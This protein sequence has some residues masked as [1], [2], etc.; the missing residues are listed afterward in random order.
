MS[1]QPSFLDTLKREAGVAA[2]AFNP[3]ALATGLYHAAAD[4][5]T[6][7]EKQ[8]Y[9]PNFEHNIGP[10]GRVI[11][12]TAVQPLVNTGKYYS[13]AFKGKHGDASNVES[14]ML[15]AAPEAFGDAGAGVVAGHVL[16]GEHPTVARDALNE[17]NLSGGST[18]NPRTGES[19]AGTRNYAAGVAPDTATVFE[20]PPTAE[21]YNNFVT[22]NRDVLARNPNAHVGTSIDPDTGHH[23]L[24]VVG[25]TPNKT[26][27]LQAATAAG[28]KSIYHLGHG[29][30]TPTDYLGAERPYVAGTPIDDRLSALADAAPSKST[31][32]GVHYSDMSGLDSIDGSR[33][34]TSGTSAEAARLRLGSQTGLGKD[35]PPGFHTYQSGSLPDAAVSG[36]KNAYNIRGQFAFGTTDSPEFVNEYNR[37]SQNALDAGADA[38]TAHRL[39]LNAGE[40]G[41]RDAGYDGY[42]APSSPNARLIFDSH[43][44]APA[45]PEPFSE[46]P[47]NYRN[48]GQTSTGGGANYSAADLDAFK[49]KH[50]FGTRESVPSLPPVQTTP[51]GGMKVTDP[52]AM[53][54][55]N[56]DLDARGI[57]PNS[58]T[59]N[60]SGDSSASQEAIN[61]NASERAQNI[62]RVR[63]DTRTGHEIPLFGVDAVDAQAGPFEQIVQRGP[64]GEVV[65]DQGARAMR[66]R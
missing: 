62:S 30:T 20:R 57:T 24:E 51:G 5:A 13:D 38:T 42:Y 7:E 17:H 55:I 27:A 23:Y 16:A 56:R 18:F 32:S 2:D 53:S 47:E 6:E 58:V 41:L 60:G 1:T 65:L 34:G 26:A 40:H 49:A 31:Y 8:E 22:A 50:G 64:Q 14:E 4:P 9:G 48:G 11:D 35:A 45:K 19:M 33:R 63:R 36:R 44:V 46:W 37:V 3:V 54:T 59:L 43:D 15:S 66:T 25:T 12:R 39:G 21:E 61:R 28:E 52:S 29:I 10:L